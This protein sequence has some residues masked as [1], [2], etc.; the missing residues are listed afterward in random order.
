TGI[1]FNNVIT[2]SDSFNI[3]TYEYIY[4]G[5]GVAIADFNNN[6]LQD[7]YFTGNMVP[8]ALYLN[9]G[10]MK[11]KDVTAESNTGGEGKWSSGVAAVDINGDGWKDLYICA[12]AH[13]QDEKR[14]NMLYINMGPDEEGI[15]RFVNMAQ[16]YG[17]AD[18]SH[19]TNAVF[20]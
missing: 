10:G 2:E 18:M 17:V 9:D 8:N 12:T 20:F 3:I 13:P 4:N 16:E 14:A 1:E 7:I 15:P 6:G 19:A 11:F 5:G